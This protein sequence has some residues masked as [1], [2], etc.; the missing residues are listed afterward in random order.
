M[1]RES[2]WQLVTEFVKDTGLRRHMQSV[3]AAMRWY[4]RRLG[5][6]EARW[7]AVGLIHDFDW[8]IHP[9][10]DQHPMKG[11]AILRSRGVDEDIIRTILSHATEGT[12]VERERPIDFALLACDEITGL[13]VATALVR[14]D[15]DIRSV[16]LKSVQ[17]KWKTPAF[18]AGVARPHVEEV[19]ADFSR[20]C[21][22]GQLGLWEHVGNVLEAMKGI[23]GDL[24]LDG[25]LVG[26]QG[27]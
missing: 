25:R 24:S 22:D 2:A 20:A 1:D 17:K 21:F 13:I 6:E 9:D 19:T 5:H 23:A 4:A 18:A 7:G 11:A 26:S 27:N 12:G 15:K 8:E 3:E 14:P 10:L 16:E